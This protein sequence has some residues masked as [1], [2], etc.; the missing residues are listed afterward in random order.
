MI[1]N[2]ESLK[3]IDPQ[4]VKL[5]L[6]WAIDVMVLSTKH[7]G[8]R[9]EN[10]WRIIHKETVPAVENSPPSKVVCVNG[11]VQKVFYLP[12]KNVPEHNLYN[13]DL[14]SILHKILVGPTPNPDLVWDGFIRLLS[15]N[16][17]ENA[18]D[19]VDMC[20]IPLRR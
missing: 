4:I 10:E 15:E 8:F 1:A 12:M 7:P 19:R 11:I 14:N 20:R 3:Q 5:N 2:Q 6:K 16:G 17:I 13:A 9:E 18:A